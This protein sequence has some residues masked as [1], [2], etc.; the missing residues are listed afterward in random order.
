MNF[1]GFLEFQKKHSPDKNY[2]IDETL[3]RSKWYFYYNL[4]NDDNSL[5]CSKVLEK[6]FPDL[7]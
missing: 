1:Q 6:N 2:Q 3:G 5:F 4:N 7:R